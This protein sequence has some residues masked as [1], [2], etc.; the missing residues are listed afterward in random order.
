[1][2]TPEVEKYAYLIDLLLGSHQ[3]VLVSGIPGVGK[4]SI[5]QVCKTFLLCLSILTL[6]VCALYDFSR[7]SLVMF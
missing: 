5:I 2:V 4:T 6:T 7:V 1:M 3:P